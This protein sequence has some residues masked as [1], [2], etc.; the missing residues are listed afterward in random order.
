VGLVSLCKDSTILLT[1]YHPP[2]KSAD[3]NFSGLISAH[4]N[5]PVF[6]E[7]KSA[8]AEIPVHMLKFIED[9]VKNSGV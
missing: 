2:G 3:P 9:N 8:Q 4:G 5:K 7:L 6:V 1:S